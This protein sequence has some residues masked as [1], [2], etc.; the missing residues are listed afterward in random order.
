[1]ADIYPVTVPKWGIE[2]QKGTIVSW[3]ADEGD[4]VS[5]GDELVDIETDKIVNTMEVPASGVL[6]RRL[7]AE[8]ETANVGTLLGV[9]APIETDDGRID[10]F[11]ADFT[12]ADALFAFD[13]EG[14]ETVIK[15]TQT[16]TKPVTEA[17]NQETGYQ[18]PHMSPAA[19]RLAQKLG[20]DVTEI[21]GT[22]RGGRIST[23][24]VEAF[25]EH[26]AA[27]RHDTDSAAHEVI[28]M[29]SRRKMIARKLV[30]AKQQIPHFY[31]TTDIAMDAALAHRQTINNAHNGKDKVSI[32]DLIVRACVL[33]LQAMPEVN[34]HVQ[35]N[36]IQQYN[37]VNIALAVATD[38]GLLTP[39]IHQAE[40][41]SLS[42][43]AEKTKNLSQ[44]ARNH[45]LEAGEMRH[46]TFTISNLGMFG[47]TAFQGVIN[48]PQAALLAVGSV[49]RRVVADG[50]SVRT[51][52]MM[53][54]SLSCDHRA[55]DGVLGARFLQQVKTFLETPAR[56]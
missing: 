7:V 38:D 26:H 49:T 45:T 46:G 40:K 42:S 17:D 52:S 44:R 55:T 43:L 5:K 32:N 21:M 18:K 48:P 27:G 29:S 35:D 4:E 37:H 28:P 22:G 20:V 15:H 56:L 53:N 19:A 23:E 50:E 39:V 10:Q 13:D 36:T 24:D 9:I 11:I 31:L 16:S 8:N 2:M 41:L 54:V 3:H 25:A 34:I 33:A 14:H 12:P 47:I 6:H 51:A 1:M 30:A